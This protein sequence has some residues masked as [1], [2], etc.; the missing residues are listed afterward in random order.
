MPVG[1]INSNCHRSS[2]NHLF[3]FLASMAFSNTE[4]SEFSL[5]NKAWIP[6]FSSVRIVLLGRLSKVF[7]I[8]QTSNCI[9][10]VT[11]MIFIGWDS[12]AINELL[13]TQVDG[14][15]LV[16]KL[17]LITFVSSSGGKSPAWTALPLIFYLSNN[18]FSP[19]IDLSI[20]SSIDW[21]VEFLYFESHFSQID[22]DKLLLSDISKLI[23]SHLP[24]LWQIFVVIVNSLNIF[25]IDLASIDQLISIWNRL[26]VF[27][28]IRKVIC[29]WLFTVAVDFLVVEHCCSDQ[30]CQDQQ[31]VFVHDIK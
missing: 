29:D 11:S 19:P 6:I 31:I 4:N 12:W 30:D 14:V 24:G 5:F 3:N 8:L 1:S 17:N 25:S 9:S 2:R 7:D 15:W 26:G 27:F 28:Q 20:E 10:S 18:S 13:F 23:D 22:R 21:L 16:P